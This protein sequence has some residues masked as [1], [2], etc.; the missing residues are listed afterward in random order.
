MENAAPRLAVAPPRPV[1]L[2]V[3]GSDAVFPVGR[4]FCIGRNYAAHAAE[5]GHDATREP[6]F[7]FMKPNTAICPPGSDYAY[8]RHSTD[9][10]HEVELVAAIGRGG[11]HIEAGAALDHV[12][13]YGVGLDMTLRDLQSTAKSMGRPWEA[14]KSVDGSAPIGALRPATETGHPTAGA[15]TLRVNGSLKQQGDL[16]Q[17]IWSIPEMIAHI[18]QSFTLREGDLIMTG[19]PSG[20]GPVLM[21]D[22][23]EGE[24]AGV[25]SVSVRVR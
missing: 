22:L 24:V 7:F 9:V 6:P 3:A 15:I 13:G 4:I 23:L 21:G 18:S 1:T 14:A 5:M 25:G 16:G 17:M 20:I 12:W 10:H 2:P 11:S 19:T 8:P